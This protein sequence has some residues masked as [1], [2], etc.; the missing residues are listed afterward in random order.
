MKLVEIQKKLKAPKGQF[1]NFGKYHYRSCED[2]IEALKPIIH[3]MGFALLMN[4]EVVQIGERYYVK[5][6]V[7]LN[8]G[9]ELYQA[10]A[11][12]REEEHKKGMDGS[13]ITGAASSYARKYAL[14]A[15]LA[16]DD[17]KDSDVTKLSD[18]TAD[19]IIRLLNSAVIPEEQKA[20][21]EREFMDYS[22]E[23]AAKCIAFLKDNQ[24]SDPISS[25]G[26]YKQRDI[27]R[28]L[29]DI[30]NDERK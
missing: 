3:P 14:N 15:L 22:E 10:T 26:N 12:A 29:D 11:Y 16:I 25:G 19:M 20:R 30:M 7:W 17:N 13:Q 28:K 27:Q 2:I 8:N 23:K 24:D 5:S 4:D 6:T 1:N 9:E 18:D 21:I